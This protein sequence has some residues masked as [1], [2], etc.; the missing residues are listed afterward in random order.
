MPTASWTRRLVVAA[1][2]A[3]C[4]TQ[5]PMALALDTRRPV[6]WPPPVGPVAPRGGEPSPAAV[7]G[8]LLGAEA[9]PG[10][11]EAALL[12]DAADGRLDRFSLLA[13]AL[14]AGG[15]TD[16]GTLR[17]YENRVAGYV[18][19]FRRSPAA[20]APPWHRARALF[21]FM[22]GRI[23][24]AGY[25][26]DCTDLAMTLETGRYNCVSGSVL[27]CHM[28]GE[29]GLV[30]RGVELPGHVM[31]RLVAPA[32]AVNVETTCPRWF[33]LMEDAPPREILGVSSS[34][35]SAGPAGGREIS[36][37]ALVATVYY[38]R[39][40]DLLARGEYARAVTANL[41]A[42][43]L[44]PSNRTARGNLLASVNNWAIHEG[45]QGRFAQAAR[46]LQAGLASQPDFE[47]FAANYVHVHRQWASTL[48]ASGRWTE[49]AHL[50][51][52]AA[53]DPLLAGKIG[54]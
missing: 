33:T 22:H 10:R 27:F 17:R 32:G 28:A 44:D 26:T 54:P 31:A 20:A 39:G 40:V 51:R 18:D 14:V 23:L 16:P 24:H 19:E 29:V 30:A 25:G 49:A 35:A 47:T 45:S 36:G 8:P 13:A 4:P 46:L 12:A 3:A 42:V 15:V 43:Q 41:R 5:G 6:G 53:A 7:F 9:T 52:R 37:V 50:V 48:R 2:L 11:L 1:V 21:E 34:A 38:N